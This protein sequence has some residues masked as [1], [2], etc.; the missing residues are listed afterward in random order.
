M[1]NV[2]HKIGPKKSNTM[3]AVA[4]G[5][6]GAIA[7]GVAVATAVVMSDKNNQQ[8][9]KSALIDSKEKATKVIRDAKQ[10]LKEK[11]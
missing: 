3:N 6:V 7:G 9:V 11:I 2:H 5:V 8:K 10:K 4:A 1:T